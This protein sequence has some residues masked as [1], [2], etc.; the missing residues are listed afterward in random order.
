LRITRYPSLGQQQFLGCVAAFVDSLSGEF[1]AATLA[2]ERLRGFRKGSAFATEMALDSHRYGTLI[3]LDR[4]TTLV[5]SFGPHV[6][7]A[8]R[9]GIVDDASSRVQAAEGIIG[10]I[11]QLIDACDT[12]TPELLEACRLGFLS[13]QTLFRE[14]REAAEQALR[15]GPM[16]PEEY[17]EARRIFSED[18][19]AR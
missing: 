18:L 13:V 19:A 5:T 1:N 3:V 15:L 8:S 7:L 12:Y 2:L 4:W 9:Q 10:R 11:N 17:R 16:L 6:Q 14:E